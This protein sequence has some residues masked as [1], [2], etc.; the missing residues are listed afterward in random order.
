MMNELNTYNKIEEKKMIK[1][2]PMEERQYKA[3]NFFL[4]L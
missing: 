3:Y 1:R 4:N 2:Q